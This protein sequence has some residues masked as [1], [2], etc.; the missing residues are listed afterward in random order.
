[1][2]DET[3][4]PPS[5]DD[6]QKQL[7]DPSGS[8]GDAGFAADP[9]PVIETLR[10]QYAKA[11]EDRRETIPITPG[12]F[13][14]LLGARYRPVDYGERRKRL[15]RLGRGGIT[16][17]S[18]LQYQAAIIAEACESIMLRPE[19]G[20]DYVEAH[21]L[22]SGWKD[23]PPVRYD[24]RLCELL[25]IELHGGERGPTIARLVFKNPSALEDHFVNLDAWMKEAMASEGDEEDRPT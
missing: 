16:D 21:T 9:L 15:R 6:A 2:P 18:E 4:A 8:N 3:G 22:V 24:A 25:K 19:P 7:E 13:N 5:T 11:S 1:M 12:R 17:E 23:G 20:A 10:E 14:S